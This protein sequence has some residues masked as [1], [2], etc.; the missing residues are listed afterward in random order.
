MTIEF[1]KEHQ[2]CIVV[3]IDGEE[4][5]LLH[6]PL[7]RVEALAFKCVNVYKDTWELLI[8][9]P[10]TKI[11]DDHR[12]QIEQKLNELNRGVDDGRD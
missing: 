9:H 10:A 8:K 3:L 6:T 11:S 7:D 12:V 5:G 4:Y 1:K 2:C